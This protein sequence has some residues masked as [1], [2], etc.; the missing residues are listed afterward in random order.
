V[1][2]C[3]CVLCSVLQE[4][5]QKYT[6]GVSAVWCRGL[7][8]DSGAVSQLLANVRS[9]Q[10]SCRGKYATVAVRTHY[11]HTMTR[12]I[13]AIHADASSARSGIDILFMYTGQSIDYLR[14]THD[15]DTLSNTPSACAFPY[16][17]TTDANLSIS[18]WYSSSYCALISMAL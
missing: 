12:V 18:F 6:W 10:G 14:K 3:K 2:L 8:S 7:A 1:E 5:R 17:S 16:S 15:A 9:G 11:I 13:W 4:R